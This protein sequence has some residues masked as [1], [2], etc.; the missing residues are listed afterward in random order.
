MKTPV[1]TTKDGI[2]LE[3][4]VQPGASR[5]QWSGILGD[6]YKLRIAAKPVDGEANKEICR[7]LAD[8]F[9]VAKSSVTI[10]KGLTGCHKTV[11]VAGDANKLLA[12]AQSQISVDQGT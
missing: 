7:F 4:H 10:T 5:S 3:L 6:A 1:R 9:Q 2:F 12:I 8:F 11:H